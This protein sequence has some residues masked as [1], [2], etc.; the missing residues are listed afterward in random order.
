M[1]H[2]TLSEAA[3]P[4]AHAH[5]VA[6]AAFIIIALVFAVTVFVEPRDDVTIVPIQTAL[7]FL[8][9]FIASAR[10]NRDTTIIFVCN[11]LMFSA[12][13]VSGKYGLFVFALLGTAAGWAITIVWS[14]TANRGFA[15]LSAVPVWLITMVWSLTA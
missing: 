13:V 8:P 4:K 2:H 9:T 3:S 14:F 7:I 12:L 6:I 11:L 1:A 15:F 10:A 5:L